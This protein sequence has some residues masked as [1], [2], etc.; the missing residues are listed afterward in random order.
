MDIPYYSNQS[1]SIEQKRALKCSQLGGFRRA[2]GIFSKKC[3]VEHTAIISPIENTCLKRIIAIISMTKL[4]HLHYVRLLARPQ[5]SYKA[6]K[7]VLS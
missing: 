7:V 6:R 3:F 1:I 5:T 2:T 4:T